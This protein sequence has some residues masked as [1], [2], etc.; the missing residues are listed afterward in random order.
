MGITN[1]F[2]CSSPTYTAKYP[3]GTSLDVDDLVIIRGI[4]IAIVFSF[5]TDEKRKK[6][7]LKTSKAEK[8]SMRVV[9]VDTLEV[10]IKDNDD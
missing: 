9:E 2:F 6:K 1:L 10:V 3:L 8:A 5:S 4:R 7:I